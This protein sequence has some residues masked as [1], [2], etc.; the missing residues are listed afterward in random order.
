MGNQEKFPWEAA[1]G[2]LIAVVGLFCMIAPLVLY[3]LFAY[4]SHRASLKAEAKVVAHIITTEINKNPDF[5]Q[6]EDMRFATLL[7]RG[8]TDADIPELRELNDTNNKLIASAGIDQSPPAITVEVPVFD[9]G[10]VVGYLRISHS[11]RDIA[12]IATLV[13]G[14][15]CCCSALIYYVLHSFPL[16]VL[17]SAF[18]ALHQEKE[19]ATITL[20]SI[21]DVV[22]TIDNDLRIRSLNPAAIH[23][24]GRQLPMIKGNLIN[25]HFAIVHPRSGKSMDALFSRWLQRAPDPGRC[26]EQA[27]LVRCRDHRKFD[28]EMT[29]SQLCDQQG[30][31]LGLV[32]VFH[33]VT[34]SRALETELQQKVTE[35]AHIVRHAGVGIAFTRGGVVQSINDNAADIIGLP[36]DKII[37]TSVA[38]VLQSCLG[39]GGPI[40]LIYQRLGQ[41]GLFDIEHQMVRADGKQIWLRLIGKAID[42]EQ[43]R[44]SGTVWIAQDITLLKERQLELE[45]ARCH[46]EEASRF[47]SQF[48]ADISHELRSPLSG[49]V[50]MTHLVLGT[51]LT[52]QQREYLTAMEAS[53]RTLLC[54]LND[55]LDLSKIEA[56]AMELEKKEV[57]LTAI[58]SYIRNTLAATFQE[59][60]LSFEFS[61]GE[62]V[63]PLL[64]GDELRLGQILLN[65]V[66]NAVKFTERGGVRV[67]CRKTAEKGTAL[68]LQFMVADSG[69]GLTMEEVEKI[70]DT[71]VQASSSVARTHGGS[72]LGLSICKKL[73]ALM[74]GDIWVESRP[75]EGSTFFFTAWFEGIRQVGEGHASVAVSPTEGGAFTGKQ[76]KNILLVED[77]LF[78]QTVAKLLL[79]N[80][81]HT[82]QVAGNGREALLALAE[83]AFD[84]IFMD[85]RM[86]IM[87]GMTATRLIRRCETNPRPMAREDNDL[88][89]AVAARVRGG[90]I[91]IIGMTGDA[92]DDGREEC[93]A[94]GMDGVVFKPFDMAG[95]MEV[96]AAHSTTGVAP[97]PLRGD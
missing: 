4:G 25:E 67:D 32:V 26:R 10:R 89:Q 19:Q 5:W 97:N 31:L 95:L 8:L 27:V 66:S 15:S 65:L 47:K 86:P 60:G 45:S 12:L 33:D 84:V 30:K 22:I 40:E 75:G 82:V 92:T 42:P 74:G 69:C 76:A 63:P 73:T 94:A 35:L 43:L 52:A 1:V 87:D 80:D 51:D 57:S 18:A 39:F 53:T 9:G 38:E 20:D 29:L 16:R 58:S 59:K 23:L 68:Q 41:G 61:I 6:F 90:H 78:N 7:R 85:V 44:E 17:R 50:G 3:L 71:F 2:R 49:I 70:F 96:L 14:V 93:R 81:G 28:V 48:L 34:D 55:L 11:A 56:G 13:L 62:D 36:R 79:E 21:T 46:A 54:L 83:C 72:G 37:G 64:M 91:A 77:L 24:I 88:I